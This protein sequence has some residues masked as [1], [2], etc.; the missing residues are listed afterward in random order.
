ISERQ[1][2]IAT[3]TVL[4]FRPREVQNYIYKENNLLT[5]IGALAGLPL[6]NVLHHYIMRQVEMNYVMFGRSLKPVSFVLA[7]LLTIFFG[8]IVNRSMNRRLHLIEMVESL[9]SVE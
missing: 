9:K 3:L 5:A 1:R 2:E 7:W 4:G 6:G 8:L